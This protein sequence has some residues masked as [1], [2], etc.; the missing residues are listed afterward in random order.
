MIPEGFFS[1]G[2][3]TTTDEENQFLAERI[4]E[5]WKARLEQ[6]FPRKRC[7]VEVQPAEETEEGPTIVVYQA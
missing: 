5:M 3:S 4:A 1:A 6:L 7:V 2:I